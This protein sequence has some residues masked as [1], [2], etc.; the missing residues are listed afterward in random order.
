MKIFLDTANIDEIKTAKR[1]GVLRGL[2]TNPSIISR[3]GKDF[4]DIAA[5]LC[6]L[7]DPYPVSLEVVSREADGMVE[8][9]RSVAKI[10]GNAV[11]KLPTNPEGLAAQAVLSEEGIKTNL[12]LI[13]STSQ[14]ILASCAKATYLSPFI[15]RLEDRGYDGIRLINDLMEINAKYGFSAEV[16][17]ASIRDPHQVIEVAKTGVHIVTMPFAVLE[18]MLANTMTDTDLNKFLSD[19]E[20]VPGKDEAFN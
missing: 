10:A 14:A 5:E 3:A 18:K 12:T 8:Q 19:W 16:I 4:K 11:I 15:G 9:A 17:A 2:T 1:W 6:A 13:F 20:N 7:V